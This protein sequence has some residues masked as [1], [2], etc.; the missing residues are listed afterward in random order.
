MLYYYYSKN[1]SCREKID[2]IECDSYEEALSYFSQKKNLPEDKFKE[3]FC[4]GAVYM[5]K[6]N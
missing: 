4:L 1:D 5:I 2:K 3:L 6:T